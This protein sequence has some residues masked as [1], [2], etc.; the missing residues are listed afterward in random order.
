MSESMKDTIKSNVEKAKIEGTSRAGR[1]GEI[2]KTALSQSMTEVKE[3]SQEIRSIASDS[4]AT[5]TGK[6]SSQSESSGAETPT[7]GDLKTQLLLLVQTIKHRLFERWQVLDTKF[8][9]RYGDRYETVKQ[10]L[11]TRWNN[12]VVW[13][14]NARANSETPISDQLQQRQALLEQK[15]G[16]AGV[17]IARKEQQLRDQVKTFFQTEAPKP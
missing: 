1:I 10:H 8:T 7:S 6:F 13:Y 12:L 15:V 4:I 5:V 16:N 3:G 17:S 14:N 11:N 2:L 9:N